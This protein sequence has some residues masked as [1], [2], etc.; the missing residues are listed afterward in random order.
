MI[1][2]LFSSTFW[3]A[4]PGV[5]TQTHGRHSLVAAFSSASC[6][7]HPSCAFGMLLIDAVESRH[8][9]G[10]RVSAVLCCTA[11]ASGASEQKRDNA[12]PGAVRPV[13]FF[14]KIAPLSTFELPPGGVLKGYF[15]IHVRLSLVY[16]VYLFFAS[17]V[18]VVPFRSHCLPVPLSFLNTGVAYDQAKHGLHHHVDAASRFVLRTNE[19]MHLPSLMRVLLKSSYAGRMSKSRVAYVQNKVFACCKVCLRERA[20]FPWMRFGWVC[21]GARRLEYHCYL[22]RGSKCVNLSVQ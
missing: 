18:F 21:C 17:C 5:R 12:P 10:Q 19:A 4:P 9:L 3:G 11:G 8:R 16:S 1:F 6:P 15:G 20:I 22:Q 13:F 2:I 7:N 14:R